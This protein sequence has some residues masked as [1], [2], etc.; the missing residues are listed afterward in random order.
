MKA[1]LQ[2]VDSAS[3]AV[4]GRTLGQ[5]GEGLLIFVGF[6]KG[7]TAALIA[8]AVEKISTLRVFPDE[9]GRFHLSVLDTKGS[10]LII[11]QFTL[12]GDTSK[13]RRPDFFQALEPEP[14]K[15]LVDQFVAAFRAKGI[16]VQEGEFG[17]HMH[18]ALE[19][20]GPV[21]LMLEW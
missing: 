9:A 8:P 18:V 20:N 21:T 19:N 7:D 14:A 12:Y 1:L 15:L 11:S 3:V 10:I 16:N 17:A 4:E 2:R 13:G 5:I 6:G